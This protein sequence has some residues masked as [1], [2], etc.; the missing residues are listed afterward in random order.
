VFF[1]GENAA[2][3]GKAAVLEGWRPLLMAPSPPF[4]WKA[5]Q[6]E[7]LASGTLAHSSGPVYNAEGKHTG[8]YNSIWRREKDGRWLVVFDKG[9]SVCDCERKP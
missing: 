3:H 4:S 2:M 8:N 9:C 5:E 7:V 6:V 1:G